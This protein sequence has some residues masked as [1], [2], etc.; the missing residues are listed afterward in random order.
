MQMKTYELVEYGHVFGEVT[1]PDLAGAVKLAG[2]PDPFDYEILETIWIEWHVSLADAPGC[3]EECDEGAA[4]GACWPE[5]DSVVFRL[6]P[7]EPR[8][9]EDSHEWVDGAVYGLGVG[10]GSFHTDTCSHCGCNRTTDTQGPNPVTGEQGEVSI[11]Y[12]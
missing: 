7:A 11:S 4:C 5:S 9:S 1:A 10:E 2:E 12:E 3:E 8:C 6:D